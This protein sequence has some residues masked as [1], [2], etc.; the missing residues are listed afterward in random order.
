MLCK[1]LASEKDLYW[2]EVLFALP[3]RYHN[4]SLYHGLSSRE[5]V[6]GR[7]KCCRNMPMNTPCPCK[8]ASLFMDEIQT[9]ENTVSK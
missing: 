7:K 5:I 1:E 2:L 4:T 9:A 3:R 8:D 6:F